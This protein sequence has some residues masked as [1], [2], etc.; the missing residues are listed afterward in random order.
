MPGSVKSG[1][2]CISHVTE[3]I[4]SEWP[5][6]RDLCTHAL[7]PHIHLRLITILISKASGRVLRNLQDN[8]AVS[9]I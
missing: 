8:S 5:R 7:M 1:T 9:D 2:H 6:P 4:C 3:V